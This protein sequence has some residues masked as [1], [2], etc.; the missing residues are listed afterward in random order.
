MGRAALYAKA[1]VAKD[2]S[3]GDVHLPSS[4]GGATPKEGNRRR[5]KGYSPLSIAYLAK[6][7]PGEARDATGRWTKATATDALH[8]HIIG[9][10]TGTAVPKS[11]LGHRAEATRKAATAAGKSGAKGEAKVSTAVGV[12]QLLARRALEMK[13]NARSSWLH[14][15]LQQHGVLLEQGHKFPARTRDYTPTP[16][17]AGAGAPY[18]GLFEGHRAKRPQGP[19]H[20]DRAARDRSMADKIDAQA[21]MHERFAA[22]RAQ[23][24]QPEAAA[25]YAQSAQSLREQAA[26][27]RRL[28]EERIRKMRRRVRVRLKKEDQIGA[29]SPASVIDQKATP[30][31]NMPTEAEDPMNSGTFFQDKL[32]AGG[33]VP[34][35]KRR[36]E[37]ALEKKFF[38]AG[39]RRKLTRT[40]AAMPGGRYPITNS[41]DVRNAVRDADRTGAGSAVRHH[42]AARARA[43]GDSGDVPWLT[44]YRQAVIAEVVKAASDS[45]RS[46]LSDRLKTG[47]AT[48]AKIGAVINGAAG[49]ALGA[50]QG[51]ALG[52]PPAYIAGRAVAHGLVSA[53]AGAGI[54]GGVGAAGKGLF[55]KS[56]YSPVPRA[57]M[58]KTSGPTMRGSSAE[59]DNNSSGLV[60]AAITVGSVA[61]DL[62]PPAINAAKEGLF[63]AA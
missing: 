55:G 4:I 26:R 44:K 49:A 42:I 40:G 18:K 39:R 52:G 6:F 10:L 20:A 16:Q 59:G 56:S 53:V 1:R 24:K 7:K 61:D 60:H 21:T 35:L 19:T 28:A 31:A 58:R 63:G 48:G 62:V 45:S 50:F 57:V 41:T 9:L 11:K 15:K 8:A 2:L 47:A 22:L 27:H 36:I 43:V 3:A 54:G 5:K 13:P 51:A 12:G 33:G 25:A 46:P 29:P 37:D 32:A 34:F 17:P 30:L 38:S 23:W 14:Q